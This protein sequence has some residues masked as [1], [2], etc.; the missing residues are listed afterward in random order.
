MIK[1]TQKARF[2]VMNTHSRTAGA[3]CRPR[4]KGEGGALR[5][6]GDSTITELHSVLCDLNSGFP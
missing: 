6:H 1:H 3:S 4:A 5:L 2:H